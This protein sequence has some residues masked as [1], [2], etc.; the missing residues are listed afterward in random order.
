MSDRSSAERKPEPKYSSGK[1]PPV[2]PKKPDPNAMP[3]QPHDGKVVITRRG[4]P[5]AVIDRM[6]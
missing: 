6:K 2:P 1:R 5:I 3:D 4:R